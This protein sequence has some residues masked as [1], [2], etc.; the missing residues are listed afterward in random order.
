MSTSYYGEQRTVSESDRAPAGDIGHARSADSAVGAAARL[1]DHPGDSRQFRRG[2]SARNRFALPR[3]PPPRETGLA[4][5]GV[6]ADREQPA[7][8]ILPPH[9]GGQ[10]A[11]RL[12]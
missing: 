3:A 2:A 12:R 11:A 1:R 7:G 5:I 6:E 8:E 4:Q 9:S 10:E